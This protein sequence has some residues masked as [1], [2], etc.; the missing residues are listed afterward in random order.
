MK[1]FDFMMGR[2]EGESWIE[3]GGQR[4]TSRGGEI[5]QRKLGGR[6]LLVEGLFK[7]KLPGQ[8][9]EVTTHETLGIISYDEKTQMYR[10]RTYV[11]RGGFGDHELRLVGERGWQWSIKRG[12]AGIV[13]FTMTLT[14]AGDWY[15]V[16]ESSSDGKEW[17]RFFEMTLHRVN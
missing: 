7:S 13:R 10:F 1:K 6:V 8:E 4:F 2:W 11:A 5:V 16:G 14:E 12:S 9:Q 3:R 15:E 17:H